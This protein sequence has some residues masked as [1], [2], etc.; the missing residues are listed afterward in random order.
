[1]LFVSLAFVARSGGSRVQPD[2]LPCAWG[3]SVCR[4]AMPLTSSGTETSGTETSGLPADLLLL[5]PVLPLPR[6]V[7]TPTFRLTLN[8]L[9]FAG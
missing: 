6:P 9:H 2:T 8:G 1:M 4:R 7:R 5:P 3:A